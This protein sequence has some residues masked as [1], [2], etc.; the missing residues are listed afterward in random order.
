MTGRAPSRVDGNRIWRVRTPDGTVLQKAYGERG[1]W[2]HVHGR[3][4]ATRLR[5]DKTSTR[6][7]GRRATE[8][9]LLALWRD[10]GLDVPADLSAAHPELAGETVLVLEDVPGRLLPDLLA[11][12]KTPPEQRHDLVTRYALSLHHR[13][14]LALKRQEAG[15][16][17]EHGGALHVIV[18]GERL[19]TFDLENGFR[20][21]A[22]VR[23]L[24]YKE[25]A[26]CLRSLARGRDAA[27]FEADLAT[28]VGAWPERELLAA[29]VQHYLHPVRAL[30]R[31]VWGLDR[32]RSERRGRPGGKYHVLAAL[33]S[34][35][36]AHG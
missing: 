5:G 16:V 3:D 4:L 9:R 10:A 34:L 2:W 13:L 29:T 25:L 30:D 35:L 18:S 33:E 23:P 28:F 19:V 20:P 6:A 21:R 14:A 32:R 22:D 31:L 12:T 7:R 36:A 17:H 1:S 8:A 27:A 11:D 24:V 15:L 26:A